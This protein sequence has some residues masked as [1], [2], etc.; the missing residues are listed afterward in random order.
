M[1]QIFSSCFTIGHHWK[2]SMQT[3]GVA[4]KLAV[5]S[6]SNGTTNGKTSLDIKDCGV[7]TH[8]ALSKIEDTPVTP[9]HQ[10]ITVSE[11]NYEK[12]MKL[13]FA[14]FVSFVVPLVV[15]AQGNQICRPFCCDAVVQGVKPSGNTGS[16]S[17]PFFY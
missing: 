8:S 16:K 9:R 6:N 3:W 1:V 15:A 12:K 4:L 7:S 10:I 2:G 14:A 13:I 5:T 11:F 17:V